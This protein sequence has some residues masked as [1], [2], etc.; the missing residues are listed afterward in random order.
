MPKAKSQSLT[1]K[2]RLEQAL[3]PND[4]QPFTVPNNWVWLKGSFCLQPMT[5]KKPVGEVFQYIDIDSINND[6]QVVTSPKNLL[7]TQ[8]P[9]R[10]SREIKE[11]DTLFSMVRPYLRNIAYINIELSKCIAS[12]GFFVCR[13][14]IIMY[15]KYL[16][17]LMISDY[18]VDG[19][20]AFM[21]GDNSPS[22][23]Q[24]NIFN[25]AFPIPPMA[26][27][28]RIVRLIESLFEKLDRANELV[29]SALDSFENR[30]AAIL[31]KAFTG[32]LTAIWREEN[33]MKL[34]KWEKKSARDVCGFITKGETPTKFVTNV[35]DIPFLKVYNIRE[36]KLDFDYNPAFIPLEIHKE[37]MK[38][39]VVYPGDIIM[40]IV[41][42][43]LQKVAIVTDQYP[44]WNINQAIAIFRP[45]A[46]IT[47][48]FLYHALLWENTLAEVLGD[49]R[50]VVGQS[51]ISLEQCRNLQIPIP[52]IDE[53]KE[54][55]RIL[56]TLLENETKAQ[57]LSDTIDKIDHMKKAILARAFRGELGTND[58][59]EESTVI[60]IRK[61]SLTQNK[62]L[63]INTR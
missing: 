18:V 8:A 36:N 37:K 27:Q 2:E 53:Q 54:I 45:T 43:P 46:S 30:K 33:G 63:H 48:R 62:L 38:R 4:E 55:V 44:E 35:G 9:S 25:F 52:H 39:S 12:T 16:Y 15:G 5:S 60:P 26:E 21:K 34:E 32:E 47:G 6:R 42:P 11:G 50:G 40:N 41:G 14:S 22:I 58:P 10:A 3:V 56:D 57:E 23:R 28:Y 13:P 49:V 17:F 19:L 59:S 1:L 29:Q 51:N 61:A 24:E 31:H 20:N 7:V